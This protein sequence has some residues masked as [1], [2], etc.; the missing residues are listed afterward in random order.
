MNVITANVLK[1][2][3]A[4]DNGSGLGYGCM[5]ITAF[6]GESMAD[7]N[8][9]ELLQAV[10]DS[11]TRHFD[12]AEIYQQNGK[13][14]ETIIGKFFK[15]RN[16]PRDSYTIATKYWPVGTDQDYEYDLVKERLV[17][18]LQRLQLDYVDLYYAHRVSSLENGKKFS[19]TAQRLKDEGLIKTIG[20][21]EV[22]GKWLEEIYA[23]HPI[24]AVQQE[25]SIMTRSLETELVPVCKKLGV[26]IIAYRYVLEIKI[27][28]CFFVHKTP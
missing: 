27:P 22:S 16:I 3:V 1:S 7:N 12:T 20:L 11:G 19:R 23:V 8:A 28:S 5:G 6:Y 21:S 15:E 24:D 4:D 18:S 9:M 13:Y 10:Y 25:W 14:N 2:V 26:V 17:Q